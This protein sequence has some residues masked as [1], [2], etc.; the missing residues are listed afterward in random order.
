MILYLTIVIVVSFLFVGFYFRYNPIDGAKIV[1]IELDGFFKFLKSDV[2]LW[3]ALIIS[4]VLTL[5]FC[6]IEITG[7]FDDENTESGINILSI[8]GTV[9]QRI[10]LFIAGYLI[11][12]FNNGS[13]IEKIS[14]G[15]TLTAG[16]L[17]LPFL[18]GIG[19][20]VFAILYFNNVEISFLF[21]NINISIFDI[22]I[23]CCVVYYAMLLLEISVIDIVVIG[24]ISA[25][26]S[27]ILLIYS[28]SENFLYCLIIAAVFVNLAHYVISTIYSFTDEECD[29]E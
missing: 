26:V 18:S 3:I 2:F 12:S 25:I 14:L 1:D 8:L 9:L 10:G 16:T 27:V 15:T 17:I 28:V 5:I 21:L 20:A 23:C 24:I 7:D 29:L 6:I 4:A 13:V 19:G 11:V 22:V